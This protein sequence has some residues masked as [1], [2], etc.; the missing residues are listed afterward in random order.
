M[1]PKMGRWEDQGID[2]SMDRWMNGWVDESRMTDDD[3]QEKSGAGPSGRAQPQSKTWRSMERC[4]KNL[5]F[6]MNVRT[7]EVA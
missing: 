6:K 4:W 5:R 1:D 3:E 2:G 7:P